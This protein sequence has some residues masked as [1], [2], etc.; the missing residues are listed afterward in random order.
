MNQV[1]IV[2]IKN[3]TEY[4][5]LFAV[6][7]LKELLRTL[8]SVADAYLADEVPPVLTPDFEIVIKTDKALDEGAWKIC[9][10][11]KCAEVS[12]ADVHGLTSGIYDLLEKCGLRF[13]VTGPVIPED[14]GIN[15]LNAGEKITV[16]DLK[17]RGIRQHIN[18]PMDI[19]SYTLIEAK[20]YIRNL[21]RMKFTSIVFHSYG[22]QWCCDSSKGQTAGHYFYGCPHTIP[23]NALLKE[24]I[25]NEEVYCIPESEPYFNDNEKNSQVAKFWLSEVI[26][27]SV[28]VGLK[29][30]FSYEAAGFGDSA[31]TVAREIMNDYPGISTLELVTMEMVG[32]EGFEKTKA[33]AEDL[34]DRIIKIFGADAITPEVQRVIN[35]C[36]R[37]DKTIGAFNY[38]EFNLTKM[39]ILK[40][41]FPDIKLRLGIYVPDLTVLKVLYPVLANNVSSEYEISYLPS[42]GSKGS[43][44]HINRMSCESPDT[45]RTAYYSWAECDGDM[46]LMQ[47]HCNGLHDLTKL[48]KRSSSNGRSKQVCINHW[49]NAENAVTLKYFAECAVNSQITPTEYYKETAAYYGISDPELYAEA[50]K[51]LGIA[52]D[53]PR[54]YAF[55]FVGCWFTAQKDEAGPGAMRSLEEIKIGRD[56]YQKSLDLFK[57][58]YDDSS[59]SGKNKLKL[60]INRIETTLLHYDS[61]MELSY[62]GTITNKHEYLKDL[63]DNERKE[64]LEYADRAMVYAKKYMLKHCEIMSDRGTEGLLSSYYKTMIYYIDHI[65][66]KYG[67]IPLPDMYESKPLNPPPAPGVR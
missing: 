59:V 34:K 42:Y 39:D 60:T 48:L 33:T 55:C 57:K 8:P 43:F 22:G 26:K 49:R 45:E 31:L 36:E 64:I 38:V 15:K 3:C 21:A 2:S 14:A 13:E 5:E 25:S 24:M 40:N 1:S 28:R 66:R 44:D 29:V 30:D 11:E 37:Y 62:I 58:L 18:F 17:L 6:K 16:P 19:S 7:D 9:I 41:E 52:S 23:Q 35:E 4:N 61:W 32:D 46:Y 10:S 12:A 53:G 67:E 47:N 51:S 20:K 65:K 50:E 27:E 63:S 56:K 54:A